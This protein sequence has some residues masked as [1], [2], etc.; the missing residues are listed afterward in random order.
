MEIGMTEQTVATYPAAPWFLHAEMFGTWIKLPARHV[1]QDFRREGFEFA[2]RDGSIMVAVY[3]VDYPAGG[4][5]SYREMLVAAIMPKLTYPSRS[6]IRR[7][8]VDSPASMAGGR[9]LWDIPKRL[10]DFEFDYGSRFN[11]TISVEGRELASYRFAP[12]LKIPGRWA[13]H[14]NTVQ[15]SLL[16][17]DLKVRRTRSLFRARMQTGTGELTVPEDSELAFLRH[18]EPVMHAALRDCRATFGQKSVTSRAPRQ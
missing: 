3:F 13:F 2:R 5:L 1:P 14:I 17:N 7:I 12:K 9:E 11:G 6:S 15:E 10:A 4:V 8:W 16:E 18:G